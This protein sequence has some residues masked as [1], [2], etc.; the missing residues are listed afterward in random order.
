VTAAQDP[1]DHAALQGIAARFQAGD[2][3][4]ADSAAAAFLAQPLPPERQLP[5]LMWRAACAN[6]RGD[7][8]TAR[9][10]LLAARHIQRRDPQLL[11]QLGAMHDRLHEL[12]Q[13]E[14]C[15]R[16]AL[17]L[18]QRLPL[19]HYN[20]GVVLQKR[21]DA[22]G[23]RRAYEAAIA[24]A[25][26]FHQAWM[27][28]GNVCRQLKDD[29]RAK[30]CYRRAIDIE[31]RFAIAHHAL[32][33]LAQM[34]GLHAAAIACFRAALGVDPSHLESWLDLVASLERLGDRE[35]ALASIDE[36]LRIHPSD[37]TL[38]FKRTVLTGEQSPTMPDAVVEKLFD[39]MASTFDEHLVGRLGYGIPKQLAALLAGWFHARGPVSVL[40]LGCGTG[41]F[42]VE[43]AA[44]KS[45]LV[46]VDLS[47]RMV[48]AA[49]SRGVY[50]ELHAA[51]ID[52]YMA[53]HS[54]SFDLV[55]A[56]DVLVYIGAL[57]TMF[58]GVRAHLY[59]GGRFAFSTESPADLHDGFRL[60]PA[61]RYAHSPA[62]VRALAGANGLEVVAQEPAVIRTEANVPIEGFV[63]VL[64]CRD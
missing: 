23:A 60:L 48:D 55:V 12:P 2:I 27:N 14:A 13:A 40:D 41:L 34:H 39:H 49:R 26:Q 63:F 5:G 15:Y 19:A 61:G 1:R 32:G 10:H 4:G 59:A 29:A 31:P 9:D 16:E 18:E 30:E 45:R 38:Q 42:G 46:G 35:S 17:R 50:D 43:I 44:A 47:A 58:E 21:Q 6:R 11:V 7:F 33:V 51:S 3:E 57:E 52:T 24:H 56:T 36:A 22:L 20:L 8:V 25:P 37:A 54:D 53:T 28:L 64:E 62:Y